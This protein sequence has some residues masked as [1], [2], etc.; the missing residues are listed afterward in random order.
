LILGSS[1]PKPH[2]VKTLAFPSPQLRPLTRMKTNPHR[3]HLEEQAMSSTPLSSFGAAD[4]VGPDIGEVTPPAVETPDNM[5]EPEPT[6]AADSAVAATETE[7][8]L[9]DIKQVR[10]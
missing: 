5:P 7:R 9:D 1:N 8:M 2:P 6:H 10:E 3:T 4:P